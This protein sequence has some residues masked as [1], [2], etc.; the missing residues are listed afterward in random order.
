MKVVIALTLVLAVASAQSGTPLA[1]RW[2]SGKEHP[3]FTRDLSVSTPSVLLLRFECLGLTAFLTGVIERPS[4]FA[5]IFTAISILRSQPC[6]GVVGGHVANPDVIGAL[7]G[8]QRFLLHLIV[9]AASVY[10]RWE[11]LLRAHGRKRE[12]QLTVSLLIAGF[13]GTLGSRLYGMI[14]LTLNSL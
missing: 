4:K 2:F 13:I 8:C 11:A 7:F 12:L 1:A 14:L 6:K 5:C 3:C 10:R 9:S